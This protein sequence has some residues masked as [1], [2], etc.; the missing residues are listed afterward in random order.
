VIQFK[1]RVKVLTPAQIMVEYETALGDVRR[2]VITSAPGSLEESYKFD[3]D[4][5][6][7]VGA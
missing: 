6:V 7:E 3:S 4:V 5:V 2:I 1:G